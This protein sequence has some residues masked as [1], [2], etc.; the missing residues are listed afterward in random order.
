VDRQVC[1]RPHLA[2]TTLFSGRLMCIIL[3][4][5]VRRRGNVCPSRYPLTILRPST[6]R[7][8]PRCVCVCVC[9]SSPCS[10]AVNL[11]SSQVSQRKRVFVF[12]GV[13]DRPVPPESV[14]KPNA[15]LYFND[16]WCLNISK[17]V[18]RKFS[19]TGTAPTPRAYA[20]MTRISERCVSVCFRPGF[21]STLVSSQRHRVWRL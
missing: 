11:L 3:R 15:A 12:G 19:T 17:R 2:T 1:F 21:Q 4:I 5:A 13:D 7:P 10:A 20:A 9:A 18:W 16:A 8:T 6:A 14:S